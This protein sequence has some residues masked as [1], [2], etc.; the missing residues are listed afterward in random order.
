MART[1]TITS[2]HDLG[3]EG[4]KR[5]VSARFDA[6]RKSYID[7]VG[8]AALTWTGDTGHASATM[9]GQKGRAEISVLETELRIVVTLPLLLVPFG[10]FIERLI[11]GNAD[12]LDPEGDP[13]VAKRV[14]D[15]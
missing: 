6:L 7:R 3:I 2:R 1:I 10:D 13:S 9:L 11:R 5:N 8:R 12:A 14:D 4:A 15:G